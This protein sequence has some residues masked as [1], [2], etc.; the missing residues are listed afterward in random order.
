MEKEKP[1]PTTIYLEKELKKEMMLACI[2]KAQSMTSFI[3]S[4]VREKLERERE[5]GK[6]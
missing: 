1:R 2:N 4:A 3:E 6:E 5:C